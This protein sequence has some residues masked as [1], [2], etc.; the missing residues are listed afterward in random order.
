MD[1]Y[2]TVHAA[3]GEEVFD[4]AEAEGEPVVE[5]DGVADNRGREPVAWIS[6]R[7]TSGYCARG[8][9]KLTMPS[10]VLRGL[11]PRG[12]AWKWN[13]L[14]SFRLFDSHSLLGVERRDGYLL[15]NSGSPTSNRWSRTILVN[16]TVPAALNL[17]SG[18][19]RNSWAASVDSRDF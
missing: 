14:S 12:G 1:S 16:L 5:P 18:I 8:R 6:A 19:I 7:Q 13:A 10:R 2:D 3:L 11:R 15:T 4:V 9:I 17:S